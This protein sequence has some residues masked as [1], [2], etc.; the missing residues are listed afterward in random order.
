MIAV[1]HATRVLPTVL[2]IGAALAVALP[3]SVAAAA[4]LPV[5]DPNVTGYLGF[6]DKTGHQ[7]RSGILAAAPFAW[8]TVSSVGA[9]AGYEKAKAA[10]VGF[11]PRPQVDSYDWSGKPLTASSTF[12][13]P[14]HPMAAGTAIDSSFG[15]FT[16]TYT[17]QVQGIV[18]V[19]MVF[20]A[21]GVPQYPGNYP[22]TL[23][24]VT[25][26]RWQQLDGGRV[27]CTAGTARSVAL[28]AL[29][30]A[31]LRVT[32]P[33]PTPESAAQA[34]VAAR[35]AEAS[36]SATGRGAPG[37]AGAGSTA[38]SP[39]G[40]TRDGAT[41]GGASPVADAAAREP[42]AGGGGAGWLWFVVA[43]LAVVLG[44]SVL[45]ARRRRTG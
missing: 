4:P 21:P 27:P 44:G 29:P 20:T 33:R 31:R 26:S 37:S 42:G 39:S 9:P 12:S 16:G 13:N 17:P 11:Q 7:V 3:G 36:G 5:T 15:D 34:A 41:Q 22:A 10:V 1:R 38:T 19:R 43:G 30:A 40:A 45:A 6:C 25:G 14:R 35:R 23:I 32:H 2:T 28:D 18:Q 8:K 24:K